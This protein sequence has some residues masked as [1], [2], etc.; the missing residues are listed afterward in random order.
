[1]LVA[2]L[3]QFI[4][5]GRTAAAGAGVLTVQQRG[6][7][8]QGIRIDVPQQGAE[9]K[10]QQPRGRPLLAV[11]QQ[12]LVATHRQH[13]ARRDLLAEH[14]LGDQLLPG[15]AAL[16]VAIREH[17]AQGRVVDLAGPVRGDRELERIGGFIAGVEALHQPQP[18]FPL[19]V[20]DLPEQ[21]NLIGLTTDQDRLGL[22]GVWIAQGFAERLEEQVPLQPQ[23]LGRITGDAQFG[24]PELLP[25]FAQRLEQ[26]LWRRAISRGI[27]FH[28]SRGLLRPALTHLFD[29]VRQNALEVVGG[30][31][32]VGVADAW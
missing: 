4:E 22:G 17:R 8:Q 27:G 32:L 2:V 31:E 1:M 9:L 14:P 18:G 11:D 3:I 13:P 21:R 7:R 19:G 29:V 30:I 5:Q 15:F 20:G 10:A 28:L 16:T 23:A 25:G 6:R 12:Q 26:C 24:F